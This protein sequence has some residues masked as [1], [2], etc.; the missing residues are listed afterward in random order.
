MDKRGVTG[1]TL[2]WVFTTIAGAVILAF[3]IKFAFD[4]MDTGEKR[5]DAES[6]VN[7]DDQLSALGVSENTYKKLE[8]FKDFNFEVSCDGFLGGSFHKNTDKVV[9]SPVNLQGRSL[10]VWSKGFRYPFKVGNMFFLSDEEERYV[11]V[12]DDKSKSYVLDLKIPSIFNLQKMDLKNF[13]L[14]DIVKSSSSLTLVFFNRVKNAD[15]FF[16]TFR[17]KGLRLIEVDFSNNLYKIY[18]KQGTV[19]GVYLNEDLLYGIIFGSENFDC[20]SAKVDENLDSII[21]VYLGKISLIEKKT[22][23]ELCKGLLFESKRTLESLKNAKDRESI[24]LMKG[25]EEQNQNLEKNGCIK[26]F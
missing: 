24:I 3:F 19:E 2:L 12:Y 22:Q 1:Y 15:S 26:I 16:E 18:K 9:F 21:D 7:L 14:Q 5:I 25:I 4:I 6:V 23:D 11:L 8:G 20:M 10:E 17:D 13:K